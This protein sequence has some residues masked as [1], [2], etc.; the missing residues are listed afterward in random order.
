MLGSGCGLVGRAVA[1]DNRDPQFESS[2]RRIFVQKIV[3][4]LS[5]VLKRRKVKE[6]WNGS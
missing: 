2:H 3:N 1:S 5:N 4:L 6:A